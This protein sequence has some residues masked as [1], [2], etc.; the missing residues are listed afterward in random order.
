MTVFTAEVGIMGYG[1]VGKFMHSLFKDAKVYDKYNPEFSSSDHKAQ[2]CNAR[3]VF[4]AVPTPNLQDGSLDTSEVEECVK[5]IN[6]DSIIVSRSTLN[7][8]TADN[9][10]IRYKKKII[11][12]PEHLG[13]SPDHPLTNS[14][15]RTFLIIGGEPEDR[16]K[17]IDLY[18]TVY[19]ASVEIMQV[20]AFEAEII[21]LGENRAIA[22]KVAQCQELYD[23]C[24]LSGVDYYKIRDEIYKI[25]PRFDTWFT[26]VYPDD[27]GMNSKCI[28]KDIFA[29]AAWCK[30]YNYY[31]KITNAILDKNKEWLFMNQRNHGVHS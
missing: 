13:E 27:R 7:P 18:H 17:L 22:F 23:M 30:Q 31:P 10:S 12:Q 25:D 24:E 26:A 5:Q 14:K 9:L 21:K 1:V 29:F 8:G 4:I 11:V 20:S 15:A 2:A 6:Y 3:I 19:N 16:R 28:P